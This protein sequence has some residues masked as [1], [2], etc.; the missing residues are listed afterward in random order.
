MGPGANKI[1]LEIVTPK[2][3]VL[4]E[5][6]DEVN[7]PA[8]GGEFGVLPGHLPMLAALATGIVG[9]RQGTETHRCAVGNGFVEA[10]ANKLLLLT[11]EFT[12]R[13]AIDPIVVRKDFAA[14][15]AQLAKMD[16]TLEN[17]KQPDWIERKNALIA[18]ENWL[19]AKLELYGDPPPPTTRPYEQYDTSV[20]ADEKDV[21]A[22]EDGAES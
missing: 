12:L 13:D 1:L 7:A 21:P 15:Q 4:S 19:A 14:T 11:D 22:G 8:V 6:V 5:T 2:G 3:R 18:R 17:R 10:G 9:Y 20:P 16:A